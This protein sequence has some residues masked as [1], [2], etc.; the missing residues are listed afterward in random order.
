MLISWGKKSMDKKSFFKKI[1]LTARFL[2]WF[3]FIALVPVIIIGYLSY[4]NSKKA[5]E[6]HAFE[7]LTTASE[8]VEQSVA[9]ILELQ[10][11]TIKAI[12][13]NHNIHA[14]KE[15]EDGMEKL[16]NG[17]EHIMDKELGFYDVFFINENGIVIAGTDKDEIGMDK[18]KDDYFVSAKAKKGPHIKD[19]YESS[20]TKDIGYAVSSAV[21][22]HNGQF[23][24]VIVGRER[25]D[26]LNS[27]I[28]SSVEI[29]AKTL[30]IYIVDE[31]KFIVT[32]SRFSG[33]GVIL[34]QKYD[35]EFIDRCLNG[36]EIT[37]FGK[38]YHGDEILGSY[39][40]N[41]LQN[42][43]GKKWCVV[44]EINKAEVEEPVVAL[45]NNI[46]IVSL[47]I[48]LAILFL[49]WYASRS[50][51]EFV[52][53]PIRSAIEQISAMA[54]QLSSSTQQ[55]SAASQQNASISQ[56]LASGSTQQSKQAEE[57]SKAVS[58]LSAAMQQMSAAAQEVATSSSA[59]FQQAQVSGEKS[60]QIA[61]M[62]TAI[63]DISEQTNLLAL[64]A[65]IEAARAGEA[66]RGFA[67][68][69]DEVRKLA[70]NSGKSAEDIKK[71][72][73]L[74]GESMGGTVSSIQNVSSKI[75]EV[76]AS[77]QQEAASIQQIAKTLDGIVAV[78][79]QTA[80]GAQQLSASSQQQSAANQQVAA[81]TQQL[82]ALAIE[83]EVLV[84]KTEKTEKNDTDLEN[85]SGGTNLYN[86]I[87]R[88]KEKV[89][90]S[91]P[92]AKEEDNQSTE[93]IK[94][95]IVS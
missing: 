22:D 53:R 90:R 44:A 36:E 81:A 73:K 4:N 76:S 13:A 14:Y 64:N 25:L 63:T 47:V 88:S 34:K 10:V 42:E 1:G 72:V 41:H 30:D 7:N 79:E 82:Q 60:E 95:R 19:I 2:G 61:E 83:M 6:E 24:G 51:S 94:R 70:E 71:I 29:G 77:I 45:R 87:E 89:R 59:S 28:Q 68:V 17:V 16:Q 66:G 65:A 31:D 69:A 80:S 5:L 74:I 40:G 49:A 3:L 56:Q 86:R 62:V 93:T 39:Q 11:E 54:S 48:I 85:Y 12:D 38:D 52:R 91:I 23:V 43:L 92:I 57:I 75:L 8:I 50:I 15:Y 9:N 33:E 21:F 35:A 26:K 32:R 67:V 55:T 27:L 58:Q 84:G 37:N 20:T 18:S 78:S 46:I